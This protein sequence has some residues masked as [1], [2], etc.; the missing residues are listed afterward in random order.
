[1]KESDRLELDAVVLNA[2]G[3]QRLFY[4]ADKPME[5]AVS[6]GRE[7]AEQLLGQGAAALIH[8]IRD[9]KRS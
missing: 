1:M 4:S 9:P 8:S 7:T 2:S 6:L 3:S 5:D